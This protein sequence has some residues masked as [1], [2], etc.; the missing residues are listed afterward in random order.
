MRNPIVRAALAAVA[1]LGLCAPAAA[2]SGADF[3]R[4]KTIR[5]LVGYGAGTGYD[6][7]MRVVQ[8]HMG[9]HLPGKPTV[10]P[11]NMPGAGGLVMTNYL[12]NVAARDGTVIGMPSRDLVTEP[13]HGNEAAKF[14]ALKFNWIGSVSSDVA[15][16]LGWRASG[17]NTL[18]DAMTREIK[19]GGNGPQTGSGVMPRMLNALIGTKF[20]TYNGYPDSAAVGMAME[21]GEVEGYCGFTLGSVRSARPQWLEKNLVSIMM[22]MAPVS[23]PDLKT[24]PNP[25]DLLK[26]EDARQAY[27]LV[28]GAGGMGRP[29]AA[30]PGVPADRV[31]ALRRAFQ[32]VLADPAFLEDVKTSRIDVDGPTD[33]AAVEA[34]IRQLYATP[35]RVVDRVTELRNR[36]D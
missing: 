8:R 9:K 14:D 19:L 15:L 2:Q 33:G 36:T 26:D 7:Y 10:I 27:L 31:A 16:C 25:Q 24:T 3:Y 17:A 35:R 23:H 6:V 34:L 4:G 11:E 22:Q 12:Y 30:P 5:F 32:D 21:Q 1:V 13:L 20:K 18:Q 29:I 28:W